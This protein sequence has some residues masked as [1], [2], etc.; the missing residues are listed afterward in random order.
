MV[1]Y[2]AMHW[3]KLE[4]RKRERPNIQPRLASAT[5]HARPLP[6]SSSKQQLQAPFDTAAS[7]SDL[8]FSR[9]HFPSFTA[10]GAIARIPS[11]V[12]P[13]RVHAG[14]L[15]VLQRLPER[16]APISAK[17][18]LHF[19]RLHSSQTIPEYRESDEFWTRYMPHCQILTTPLVFKNTH[20][21]DHGHSQL[22]WFRE[23]IAQTLY[24]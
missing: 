20:K 6:T 18:V 1:Q 7:Y 10:M 22:S 14:N 9:V 24:I 19:R 4:A 8:R 17:S 11:Y 15:H 21:I 13:H 2:L 16:L 12:F 5:P 23:R 3:A